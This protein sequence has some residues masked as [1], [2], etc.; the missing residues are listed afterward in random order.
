MKVD[1]VTFFD[2]IEHFPQENLEE[3]LKDINS[4][5]VCI[6]V[7]WCHF[8]NFEQWKHRKP[9]EHFHHFD[10]RGLTELL[11]RSGFDLIVAA[12]IED[13]VRTNNGMKPN[14]LTVIGKR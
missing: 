12:S 6:S 1:L 7:P 8:D 10:V 14:I 5:H 9:N 11:N 2:C 4:N 3:I 13:Q